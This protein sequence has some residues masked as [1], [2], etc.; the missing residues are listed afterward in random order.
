MR[1]PKVAW[2][3]W[4]LRLIALLAGLALPLWRAYTT[5]VGGPPG[6]ASPGLPQAKTRLWDIAAFGVQHYDF[7]GQLPNGEAVIL[8]IWIKA[9]RSENSVLLRAVGARIRA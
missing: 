6:F 2:T 7:P 4:R 1:L 8:H 9:L 3:G 5:Y